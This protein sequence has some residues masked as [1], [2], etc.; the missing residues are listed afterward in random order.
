MQIPNYLQRPPLEY[1]SKGVLDFPDH[2]SNTPLLLSIKLEINSQRQAVRIQIHSAKFQASRLT[3][4]ASFLGYHHIIP[5]D[6]FIGMF[7]FQSLF[8]FR[9]FQSTDFYYI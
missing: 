6:H 7:E 4:Q 8:Y 1:W 9:G 5:V 3:P 2:Y